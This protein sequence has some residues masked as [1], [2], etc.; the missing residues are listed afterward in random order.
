MEKGFL[1]YLFISD[2]FSDKEQLRLQSPLL[3]PGLQ[4][5]ESQ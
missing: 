2:S 3:P 4:M 5:A 1:L